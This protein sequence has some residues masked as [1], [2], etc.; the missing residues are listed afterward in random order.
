MAE[1]ETLLAD[2]DPR[3]ELRREQDRLAK[4]WQAFK[5]QEDE[6]EQLR[7]ERPILVDTVAEQDRVIAGLRTEQV[8]LKEA[9]GFKDRHDEA[10]RRNRILLIEVENLNREVRAAHQAVAAG[11]EAAK[12]RVAAAEADLLKEQERLA[13]LFKVYEEQ[14]QELEAARARLAKWESWFGRMEP[15]I[16]AL[17][18]FFADAPRA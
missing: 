13:K 12:Q 5:G 6:L 4:L 2:D 10:D 11:E 18:K 9:A 16:T 14:Q 1:T 7:R 15:A 17:P 3:A 8:A